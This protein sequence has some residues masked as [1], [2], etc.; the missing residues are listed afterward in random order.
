MKSEKVTNSERILFSKKLVDEIEY[1][2]SCL[3]GLYACDDKDFKHSFKLDYKGL[4]KKIE[5]EKHS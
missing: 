4:L 3:T 2:L 5:K 1:E